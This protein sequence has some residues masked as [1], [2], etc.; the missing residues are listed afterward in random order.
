MKFI[1]N[2]TQYPDTQT[3]TRIIKPSEKQLT[4]E[5]DKVY[6]YNQ[7]KKEKR[8]LSNRLQEKKEDNCETKKKKKTQETKYLPKPKSI[9]WKPK[10]NQQPKQT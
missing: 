8:K 2:K 1:T 4:R 3:Q 7:E 5:R 6:P 9:K 10:T